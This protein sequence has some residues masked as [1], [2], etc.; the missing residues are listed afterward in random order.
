MSAKKKK[1][2]VIYTRVAFFLLNTQLCTF[3]KQKWQW[4]AVRARDALAVPGVLWGGG[5]P[6]GTQSS[7]L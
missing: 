2:C 7:Q 4:N 6:P 3:T 5:L 1:R